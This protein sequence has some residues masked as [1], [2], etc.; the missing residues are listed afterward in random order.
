MR[1]FNLVRLALEAEVLHLTHQLRRTAN[2]IA[3]GAC[4]VLLLVVAVMF[5]HIAVWYWLRLHLE[6]QYVALIFMG[7]DVLLAAIL[8]TVAARSTPGRVELEAL[9]LRRRALDDAAASLTISAMAVRVMDLFL[10]S[11]RR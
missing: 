2:R 11:R 9:S 6:A 8:A 5:G 7:A 1:A 3:L 4:A 10:T